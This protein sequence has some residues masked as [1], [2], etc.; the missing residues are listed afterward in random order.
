MVWGWFK[1]I[2]FIAHFASNPML[3]LIWQEVLTC[4]PEIGDTCSRAYVDRWI[5]YPI[6]CSQ[7]GGRVRGWST[8]HPPPPLQLHFLCSRLQWEAQHLCTWCGVCWA[9][10]CQLHLD[11]RSHSPMPSWME[12]PFSEP[13]PWGTGASFTPGMLVWTAG[14]ETSAHIP[15]WVTDTK[16]GGK[17]SLDFILLLRF[18]FY[19]PEIVNEL[20]QWHLYI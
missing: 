11:S 5:P 2:T 4:G 17:K 10:G 1:R 9:C 19:F 16:H 7:P 12:D 13:T 3:L 20:C 18:N 8:S 15:L 6:V 14:C